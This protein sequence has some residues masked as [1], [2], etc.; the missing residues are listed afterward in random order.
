MQNCTSIPTRVF[1]VYKVISQ[2]TMVYDGCFNSVNDAWS[3]CD[4]LL[5]DLCSECHIVES[6]KISKD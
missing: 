5:K 4:V 2:S 3:R 1:I 6:I